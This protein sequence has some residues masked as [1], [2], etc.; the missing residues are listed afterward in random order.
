MD[1]SNLT[2]L[3]GPIQI[4]YTAATFLFG[5]TTV[6][7]YLYYQDFS[8]DP[9]ILRILVAV[10]WFIDLAHQICCSHFVYF[11]TVTSYGNIHFLDSRPPRS[12]GG[13]LLLTSLS[14]FLVQAFYN[15]RIWSAR[16]QKIIASVLSLLLLARLVSSFV[17]IGYA[18][19]M[20][21][22]SDF[23]VRYRWFMTS[24]YIIGA[25]EDVIMTLALC[26]D[27]YTQRHSELY[28]SSLLVDRLIIWVIGTGMLTSIVAVALAICFGL[29]GTTNLVWAAFFLPMPRFFTN[30]MLVSLNA[31]SSLRS[32]ETTK[33]INIE[34][35]FRAALSQTEKANNAISV[36]VM[37]TSETDRKGGKM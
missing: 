32:A 16:G 31:R 21:S 35:E 37:V 6:Q 3:L 19:K 23:F 17:S 34:P 28:R 10:I 14:L 8:D 18:E 15:Y 5:L 2:L 7:T 33:P 36:E 25:V 20:I 4:G 1:T 9:R 22:I 26:H 29:M 11:V 13:T 30:S 12:F 24:V 27:W